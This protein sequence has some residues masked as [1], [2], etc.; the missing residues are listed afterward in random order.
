VTALET[1]PPGVW[2]ALETPLGWQ[3]AIL[4]E[5]APARP[6]RFETVRNAVLAD[7]TEDRQR[8]AARMAVEAMVAGYRV[9]RDPYDPAAFAARAAAT[10]DA[11][12]AQAAVER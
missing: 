8:A 12:D 10:L 5:T 4:D 6:A 3:A 1:L 11:V 9:E 2:T 7:W